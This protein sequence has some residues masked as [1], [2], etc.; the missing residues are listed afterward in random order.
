MKKATVRGMKRRQGKGDEGRN[1]LTEDASVPVRA[2]R[3]SRVVERRRWRDGDAGASAQSNP[4]SS[5]S[6]LSSSTLHFLSCVFRH[7]CPVVSSSSLCRSCISCISLFSL[8]LACE[9]VREAGAQV[10]RHLLPDYRVEPEAPGIDA[11]A[12]AAAGLLAP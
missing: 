7:S 4:P 2:I 6:L 10:S 9:R 11:T 3:S 5:S 1:R 12:A 8:L